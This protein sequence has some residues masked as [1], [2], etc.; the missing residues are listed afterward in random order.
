MKSKPGGRNHPAVETYRYQ[1]PDVLRQPSAD[2]SD[3]EGAWLL[4]SHCD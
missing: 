3:G 1:V 2:Q 4:V